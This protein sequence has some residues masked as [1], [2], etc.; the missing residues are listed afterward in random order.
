MRDNELWRL[1]SARIK[2]LLHFLGRIVARCWAILRIAMHRFGELGAAEAAASM[3]YYAIFSLFPLL[4]FLVAVGS[5]VLRGD[6]ARQQVLSFVTGIFPTA[7]ELVT[8]NIE[9]VL[10][11]RGPVGA[12]AAIGFLWS[13]TGFFLVLCRNVNRA[14]PR[15]RK[16]SVVQGR[17][18]AIAMVASLGGFVVLWLISMGTLDLLAR[19][20]PPYWDRVAGLGPLIRAMF[21]R[22]L[23]WLL[24][25]LL[26][27]V[28]YRWVPR[29]DVPWSAAGLS[30]LAASVAWRIATAGFAWYVS[31]GLS[32]YRL[33][34][35]SLGSVVALMFWIYLTSWVTLFG[36]HLGAAIHYS[37]R[38]RFAGDA[39]PGR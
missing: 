39:E 9:Q 7:Q 31:S 6:Q 14:W 5:L 4:L 23:P 19:L 21:S 3:A 32:R 1:L 8:Q 17:L 37:R 28:L 38:M 30:A 27:L 15:A 20:D 18:L 22:V 11:L 26:F 16:R 24:T 12:I 33:V 10:S 25:Y 29:I 13:A 36:A 34:Y 35:G 2:A